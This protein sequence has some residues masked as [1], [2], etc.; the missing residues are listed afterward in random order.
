VAATTQ[1][2]Q[3]LIVSGLVRWVLVTIKVIVAWQVVFN[4]LSIPS[5]I[6][7]WLQSDWRS[8]WLRAKDIGTK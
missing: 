8:E 6:P 3:Q 5:W 7:R 4:L 2:V 1:V